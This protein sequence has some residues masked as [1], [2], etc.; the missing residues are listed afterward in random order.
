MATEEEQQIKERIAALEEKAS[1]ARKA[2]RSIEQDIRFQKGQLTGFI[3]QRLARGREQ[4]ALKR[5][6]D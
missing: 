4:R 6:A 3:R 2:L 1:E 5:G